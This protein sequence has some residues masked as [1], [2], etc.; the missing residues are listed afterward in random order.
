MTVLCVI[1]YQPRDWTEDEIETLSALSQ[2]IMTE[3]EL[4]LKLI[5]NEEVKAE[6]AR[7]RD[8]L[9]ALIDSSPDYIFIK[10][11]EGRFVISNQAHAEAA[12]TADADL[13]VGKTAFDTFP[14]NLAE[15]YDSDDRAVL[16]SGEP[17]LNLERQTVDSNGNLRWVLTTKVPF[18]SR[19]GSMKGVVG[20]SR[21]ITDRKMA[22]MALRERERFIEQALTTSP[23]IVY[24]YDLKQNRN[25]Y[26]NIEI[27]HI[28]GYSP[29]EIAAMGSKADAS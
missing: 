22:E 6:L 21:D 10:D 18:T 5:E 9:R 25:I 27:A 17:L 14:P 3:A 1:D 19:D 26:S 7:E 20:I 28:L 13:L 16:Q 11:A 12:Q 2:S 29:A 24:V 4:S 23:A 8:L 15:Q